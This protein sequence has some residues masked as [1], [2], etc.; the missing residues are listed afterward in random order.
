MMII[1]FKDRLSRLFEERAEIWR[2]YDG[3]DSRSRMVATRN[4]DIDIPQVCEAEQRRID[5]ALRGKQ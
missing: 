1:E 4:I 2:G 3:T 5:E